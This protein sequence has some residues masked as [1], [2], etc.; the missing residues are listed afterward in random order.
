M[1][2]ICKV[3]RF[4]LQLLMA[5]PAIK[6]FGEQRIKRHKLSQNETSVL[7]F[8]VNNGPLQVSDLAKLINKAQTQVSRILN[9]LHDQ[10]LVSFKQEW[11]KKFY[12]ASI[13]AELAY[14]EVPSHKVER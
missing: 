4:C 1:T 6:Q 7:E 13:D 10:K 11:R 9:N 14:G 3:T 2:N 12:S 5:K 8:V